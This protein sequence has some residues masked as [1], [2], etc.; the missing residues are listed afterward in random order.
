MSARDLPDSRCPACPIADV[1]CT[2]QAIMHAALSKRADCGARGTSLRTSR[3]ELRGAEEASH[4]MVRGT[5]WYEARYGTRHGMV[6][7]TVWY[8]ARYGTR[9]GIEAATRIAKRRPSHVIISSPSE[10][11]TQILNRGGAARP[12]LAVYHSARPQEGRLG[13]SRGGKTAA[14]RRAR[15][16]KETHNMHACM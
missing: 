8:E 9:H 10:S 12:L 7:A 16:Y 5:V 4:G 6:R 11:F 13:R 1:P 3:L 2:W 14:S 15:I